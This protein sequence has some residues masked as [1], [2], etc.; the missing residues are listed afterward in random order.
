MGT[1]DVP[2]GGA[3]VGV[4]VSG[5]GSVYITAVGVGT[6]V[7][8]FLGRVV[9]AGVSSPVDPVPGVEVGG[10]PTAREPGSVAIA[11]GPV[12]AARSVAIASDLA[13][14]NGSATTVKTSSLSLRL[15]AAE[16]AT[17]AITKI[18]KAG[19]RP[20]TVKVNADQFLQLF[21]RESRSGYEAQLPRRRMIL[22]TVRITIHTSRA[23]EAFLI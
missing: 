22:N 2:P 19:T 9:M 12:V 1:V 4:G 21:R 20:R 23:R 10:T 8:A 13:S 3:D 14:E 17:V 16:H 7:P 15:D 11:N 5:F 6:I 18:E